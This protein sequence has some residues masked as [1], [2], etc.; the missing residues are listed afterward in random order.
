MEALAPTELRRSSIS[1]W[2]RCALALAVL[3]LLFAALVLA[4]FLQFTRPAGSLPSFAAFQGDA[5]PYA[6]LLPAQLAIVLMMAGTTI[7]VTEGRV[8]PRY[9][10]GRRLRLFGALYFAGSL[11]RVLIGLTV[12][13]APPWFDAWI[14]AVFHFVL[15]G[16]VLVLAAFH[17]RRF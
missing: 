9:A 15:A 5:L 12:P 10:R 2:R 1:H 4:Q 16:F 14:P 13:D 6:V 17:L 8:A 11:S 3:T 7:S